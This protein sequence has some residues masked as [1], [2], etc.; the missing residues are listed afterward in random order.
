MDESI[1]KYL[2]DILVSIIAI[3]SYLQGKRDFNFYLQNK[4]VRRSVEREIEIIGEAMNRLLKI[5][6][7]ITITS[8]TKI[9]D[10]RN[11]IIHAYDSIN[12]EIIW[13]VVVK[14]LPRLKTE[15][16]QLLSEVS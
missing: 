16:E 4:I 2:T 13:N 10:Q 5:H 8:A 14:H 6:P 3:D 1:K 11:L 15:V 9:V 12:N 7:N